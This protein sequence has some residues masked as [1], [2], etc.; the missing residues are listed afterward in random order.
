MGK[1]IHRVTNVNESHKQIP[2]KGKIARIGLAPLTI[3]TVALSGC[4]QEP[5]TPQVPIDANVSS[6][7]F[8]NIKDR[9]LTNQTLIPTPRSTEKPTPTP[10]AKK[11]NPLFIPTSPEKEIANPIILLPVVISEET[12]PDFK[13]REYLTKKGEYVSV[14]ESG[15]KYV[16]SEFI[17]ENRGNK[18]MLVTLNRGSLKNSVLRSQDG[19]EYRNPIN[20]DSQIPD[21][22]DYTRLEDRNLLNWK[23]RPTNTSFGDFFSSDIFSSPASSIFNSLPPGFRVKGVFNSLLGSPM[24]NFSPNDTEM[25]IS[26]VTFRVGEKTSGYRLNVPNLPEIDLRKGIASLSQLKFP[27]DRPDSDFK[28]PGTTINIPDKGSV[29]FEG[30]VDRTPYVKNS[31][32]KLPNKNPGTEAKIKFRFHNG[33]IGYAQSFKLRA[34]IFGDDGILYTLLTQDAMK[35]FPNQP[36]YWDGYLVSA[37]EVPPGN[38]RIEEVDIIISSG[39]KNGKLVVSGDINEIFNLSLPETT[40]R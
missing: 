36:L 23:L 25:Y 1:E 9:P 34:K 30:I 15:W 27:T 33:S 13:A 35:E 5:T 31:F 17:V 19:F 8:P 11:E 39:L 40:K 29:T 16:Y 22:N 20:L 4:S 10:I 38:D 21:P 14:P 6:A 2:L 3:A 28:N 37:R 26:R 7:Q 24:I 12:T 32:L 18:T